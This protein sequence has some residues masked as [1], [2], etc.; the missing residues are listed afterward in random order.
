MK[1]EHFNKQF[2]TPPASILEMMPLNI[3]VRL[4]ILKITFLLR[5]FLLLQVC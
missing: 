5:R 1:I 2:Q 3:V 4:Y